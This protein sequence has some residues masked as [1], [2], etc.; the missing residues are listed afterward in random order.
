MAKDGDPFDTDGRDRRRANQRRVLRWMDDAF[1]ED[2]AKGIETSSARDMDADLVEEILRDWAQEVMDR[3]R[4][5]L[6]KIRA[7][8]RARAADVFF[9]RV[10]P[11]VTPRGMRY[12]NAPVFEEPWRAASND[13]ARRERIPNPDEDESL[14]KDLLALV[15]L[16]V[17]AEDFAGDGYEDA[18]I[19][20]GRSASS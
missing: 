4:D 14:L 10:Q 13:P 1:V 9:N 2:V 19:Q 8:S 5:D 17:A 15:A 12:C 6:E 3:R 11:S 20:R 16:L 18:R 7:G